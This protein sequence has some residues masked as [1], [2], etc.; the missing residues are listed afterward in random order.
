MKCPFC[1]CDVETPSREMNSCIMVLYRHIGYDCLKVPH[2]VVETYRAAA[3]E[4]LRESAGASIENLAL[5]KTYV[6]ELPKD[7]ATK[8]K[9]DDGGGLDV[10][11]NDLIK[12]EY[13]GLDTDIV[14]R[15]SCRLCGHVIFDAELKREDHRLV[16]DKLVANA[17][18]EHLGGSHSIRVGFYSCN[19]PGC[20]NVN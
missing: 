16:D 5:E 3:L 10:N 7:Y 17:I 6:G 14:S 12:P 20:R 1:R 9:R 13:S 4:I 8:T 15:L 18:V 11:I 2:E 19:D